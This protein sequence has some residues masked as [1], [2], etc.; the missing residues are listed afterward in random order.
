[1]SAKEIKFSTDARDRMLRGVE[2][3]NNAVKVTL[4]P[5]GRNVIIDKAYGAPRITK[6]GV[7]VA[8]EIELADKFENMG[9]QM[10]RE[11]AS[12]TNDLAGDGTT[13]ATV[14]AASILREGAKFVAAGMNPMDLKRGID[15]AV[16]AVVKEIQA[17]AKKVKS[18]GEIAQV[19]TIAANGDATVGAMIAKAMDKVGNDGVITVEEAKTAE[20]EL[21]VVEGMQFDRGYLSPYFVTNAEKMRVELEDPYV[22]I[23]EKKL[24]NL[25]AMLPILEAVVQSGK[26]LVIISEDVEGEALAT[27]VVNK[28]RGGLKVAAV[29][30]PGF[31]DRRKAMLEDIA[32]L[33]AGQM[34]SEDLGIKLENITIDMLGRAKR[35][36]IEKDTTTIIDGAGEKATIQARVQQIKGQIEET[37][38]DYDKEKLQ[39]RLAKLAGGVAVIRVGGATESEVKEKKDR[40]D[41]ALNAT[42]AAVEEGIVPGGGVA[43]L[44]AKA[45]LNG[46]TGANA[47]VTA[48][49]SIVSRALE[50]P[51]RQIA[52]N[53]G[54]EGSIVVGRLMDSKDHNQGFDAQNEIYVDMIK[55][56]IV[57]PAKVVRTAL[58]DAGSIAALLITAEAMITDIPAKDAAPAAG[59]GMGGY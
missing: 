26:P 56:G 19:G 2:I 38:S 1:M 43:L 17:R 46:L 52:E 18:S 29:K 42:R 27:L 20:T 24:G 33:T 15:L 51:I 39:E 45:V 47:D 14:L 40:I 32:V 53:S 44:R 31:G 8:K 13:T 30:A 54:V 58:Q 34:I 22:L 21:D 25:Q 48:G 36:L 49:I 50:A 5:K 55:V 16:T 59:G 57:D 12:K 6:D 7:T 35:V 9:A 28:L 41:D 3:L 10:V 23:H 37:T 11:V 4:G